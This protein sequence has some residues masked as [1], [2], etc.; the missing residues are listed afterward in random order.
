MSPED[1]WTLIQQWKAEIESKSNL[2]VYVY[3]GPNRTKSVNQL[4]NVDCVLNPVLS[5]L[6]LLRFFLQCQLR[7]DTLNLLSGPILPVRQWSR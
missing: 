5:S 4:K 3:H 1:E 7:L 2:T 6:F